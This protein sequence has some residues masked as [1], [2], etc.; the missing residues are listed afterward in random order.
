MKKF[1]ALYLAPLSELKK[2]SEPAQQEETGAGMNEWTEW[3]KKNEDAMVDPG[4]PLGKTKT[5]TTAGISDT[6]N[7][8]GGYS[9]VQAES[10]DSAAELFADNPHLKTRNASIEIIECLW[11]HGDKE[12]EE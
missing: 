2:I 11:M 8:I 1:L 6:K 3:M 4:T 10:H 12:Q 7:K 9:V 5:V